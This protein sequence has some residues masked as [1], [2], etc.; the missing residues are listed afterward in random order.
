MKQL[1]CYGLLLGLLVNSAVIAA[2]SEPEWRYTIRPGDTLIQFSTRYLVKTADWGQLQKLN[3]IIN[4]RRLIPGQTLRIP[5]HLLKQHPAPALVLAVTG[6]V[7]VNLPNSAAYELHSGEKLYSGAKLHTAANSS[8]TLQF[9]DGSTAMVQPNSI[10]QLDTMSVYEGG[11]M[12]D[13]KLRLQQGRAE[14]KANPEHKPDNRME[15]ITP[16]AVAAVRGTEFRVAVENAVTLEETLDGRVGLIAANQE[17]P[18]AAGYG[19]IAEQGKPARS[20]V[21]LLAAPDVHALPIKIDRLPMRFELAAQESAVGWIGQIAPDTSFQQVLLEKTS[22]T[23]RLSFADLP[24]GK[25]MLRV[26]AKDI[27]GLQGV[28]A[29]HAFEL[30]AR[31]F[32]PLLLTPGNNATVRTA[33]PDLTWSEANGIN[34]Y[35]IQL[36]RDIAFSDKILDVSSSQNHLKPTQELTPGDYYLHVAS[37][38]GDDQGP[39]SDAIKFTYK[40]APVAPDLTLSAL[41][42]DDKSMYVSLPTPLEGL[43]YEAE[44]ASDTTRNQVLWHGES[45]DGK[46]QM[47]RP[48]AGKQYLSVRMIDTD[49]TTSPFSTQIIEVPH[50]QHWKLLLL[51]P[52]FAL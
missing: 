13:T 6:S 51:L 29:V 42:F 34:I 47:P 27:S 40:P 44:L 18:I 25:Y 50:K 30:N 33:Q 31:P 17:V 5:L 19:S 48:D 9:A 16:S 38:A 3:Q 39:F 43:R 11:G 37:I 24:D 35:R 52:L 8:A 41:S 49:G 15:V 46:L 2:D 36:A 21:S 7:Q 26:R 22:D 1:T 28:D 45:M 32:A 14:I 23:P 20:P 12:V 10:M 4:P